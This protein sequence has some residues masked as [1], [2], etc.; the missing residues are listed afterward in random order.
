MLGSVPRR[1]IASVLLAGSLTL[2]L[3]AQAAKAAPA[4]THAGAGKAAPA[5]A[6]LTASLWSLLVSLWTGDSAPGNSGNP[7]PPPDPPPGPN[8]QEGSGMCPHGG[9]GG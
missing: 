8:G 4:A 3:A 5:H 2:P 7:G 9:H 1:S 6:S